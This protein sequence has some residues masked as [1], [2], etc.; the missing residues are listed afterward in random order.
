LPQWKAADGQ[1]LGD[2]YSALSKHQPN[3]KPI[4]LQ[5]KGGNGKL[6]TARA[7]DPKLFFGAR[8]YYTELGAAAHET[9][10]RFLLNGSA[11]QDPEAGTLINIGGAVMGFILDADSRLAQIVAVSD[12]KDGKRIWSNVG[13]AVP[14]E[15]TSGLTGSVPLAVKLQPDTNS[16][17]LF[18]QDILLAENLPLLSESSALVVKLRPGGSSGD[19][20]ILKDL[21]VKAPARRD[22]PVKAI[23]GR[24][25]LAAAYAAG[26]P[27]VQKGA[28]T[29]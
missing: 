25:D 21:A 29:P 20:A 17:S 4:K 11:K 23:D 1:P 2:D 14:I 26:V 8:T 16:W 15:S 13:M 10:V 28:P 27:N 24:I 19:M 6:A 7:L 22:N 9:S 12:Y 3:G 18:V 5:K